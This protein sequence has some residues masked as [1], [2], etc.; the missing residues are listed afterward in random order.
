MFRNSIALTCWLLALVALKAQPGHFTYR[1][2]F[3]N[4]QTV[5]VETQFFNANNPT[6]TVTLPGAAVGGLDSVIH[7]E[8]TFLPVM[9]AYLTQ[10]LCEGDTLWVNGEAYH[11]GFFVGEEFIESGSV[12]GCDSIIYVNLTFRPVFYNFDQPICEGDSIQ[13]NGK[14][15]D[16]FNRTGVEVVPNGLCDSIILV[17]LQPLPIS[18]SVIKDTLCP[19]ET[20]VINGNVYSRDNRVGFEV[21][22]NA[23]QTGCDSLIE[24]YFFF[25]E[26][27][28]YIGEDTEIVKGD[29]ICIQAQFGLMPKSLAWSPAPPCDDPLCLPPCIRPLQSVFYSLTAVDDSTGCV[30]T[31][32]ISIR[33]SNKNRVYAPNVFNPDSDWPNNRFFLSGDRGVQN[34]RRL[35]IADR[36]GE[37]LFDAGNLVPGRPDSGWDGVY[38]GQTM[39]PG[40]Y[41]FWAE[42]ERIDGTTFI[43]SGSFALVR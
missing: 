33:V 37:L 8:L 34:I 38:R 12:N 3:C 9:H 6:G 7:V 21:L 23:A 16:A 18:F 1:D 36:W 35:F 14:W 17:N 28:L 5:L 2:T 41:I 22:P 13:I 24:V 32:D 42:I 43:E 26:L 20:R 27:W 39:P 30:L 4:N 15:Y 10:T 25:H 31:D 29:T 40:I 11:A 19:G